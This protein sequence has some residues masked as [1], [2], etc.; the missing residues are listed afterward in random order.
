VVKNLIR[1]VVVVF[2]Y[3]LLLFD[4]MTDF[5]KLGGMVQTNGNVSLVVVFDSGHMVRDQK[6][7]RNVLCS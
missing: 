1:F 2:F 3:F 5:G 7:T 4:R 6:E